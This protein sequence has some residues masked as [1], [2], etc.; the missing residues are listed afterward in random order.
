MTAESFGEA[1]RHLRQQRHV[2]LRALAARITYDFGYLGQVERG[3]RGGSADLAKRC[4]DA[5]GADGA[6]YS[7]FSNDD[8]RRSA[9]LLSHSPEAQPT[10]AHTGSGPLLTPTITLAPTLNLGEDDMQRRGF[11][12][13]S[14][15]ALGAALA[16]PSGSLPETGTDARLISVTGP[17]GRIFAGSAVPAM[18]VPATDGDRIMIDTPAQSTGSYFLHRPE[19]SLVIGEVADEDRPALYAVDTRH[20]RRRLSQP[21][22][23]ARLAIPRA[24]VLDELTLGIIWAIANLDDALLSDDTAL[25]DAQEQLATFGKLERSSAGRDLL[26]DLSPVSQAWVGSLFCADHILRHSSTLQHAPTFWTCERRGEEASGWLFFSH[27]YDYLKA[28]TRTQGQMNRQGEMP[29][30][31]CIPPDHVAMSG[32]PERTILLLA[33]ALMESFGIR[34][35]VCADPA[36]TGMEGF[37]S[38]G[39]N[40]IVANWV[41]TDS[42]WH[43]DV[44]THRP[45]LTEYSDAAGYASTHSVSIGSNPLERL[46]SLAHYLELDWRAVTRRC[47]ELGRYGLSGLAAPRSRLLSVLGAERACQFISDVPDL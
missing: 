39:R 9:S 22:K 20:V 19:H 40:A 46:R 18:L 6:L 26:G 2:S 30:L 3:E 10:T 34:I 35:A 17:A 43:V 11:L 45:T 12:I 47:A 21:G 28:S 44:T 33:A 23:P 25:G 15:L 5:L 8:K 38:D 37:V 24:Y 14:A 31:F 42:L 36:Y 1:L 27:K 29:R 41:D 32:T 7:A 13:R 16:W 4:D